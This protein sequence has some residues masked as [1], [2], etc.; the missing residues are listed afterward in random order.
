MMQRRFALA[1]ALSVTTVTVFGLVALGTR[2]GLFGAGTTGEPAAE[3]SADEIAGA[4]QYLAAVSSEP[5]AA[6]PEVVTEYVYVDAPAGPPQVRYITTSGNAPASAAPPTAA[7]PAPAS[8]PGD[9]PEEHAEPTV[10]APAPAT[11]AQPP[12]EH[13]DDDEGGGGGERTEDEFVGIVSAVNGE[14]VTFSHDGTSTVVRVTKKLDEL[15]P[16]VRAKVHALLLA[17]GWVAKE[18]E[19]KD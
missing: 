9:I 5:T 18:I 16:G 2:G 6:A 11:P 19:V 7:G 12:P 4:L 14:L 13:E 17:D 8:G 1:L 10:D 15:Q 3:A